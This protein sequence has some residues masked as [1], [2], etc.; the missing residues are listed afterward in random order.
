VIQVGRTP[1]N[2]RQIVSDLQNSLQDVQ[3]A[4]VIDFQGLSVGEISDLRNRIRPTGAVCKVTKNTLM[5]RAV[6]GNDDW[7]ALT[8]YMQGPSAFMLVKDDLSA[9][10]SYQEFQKATKKTSIRGAV[11]EGKKLSESDVKALGDLP[12]KE[13]LMAQIAG[14]LNAITAKIAIGVKE[15]PASIARGINAHATKDN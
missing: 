9:I 5:R 14:T 1:E 11:M 10:K 6:D 15:V 4:V 3:M 8:D 13:V 2:K 7:Q 12:S